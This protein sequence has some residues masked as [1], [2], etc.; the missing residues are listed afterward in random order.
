MIT[1]LLELTVALNAIS[2][3]LIS[4]FLRVSNASTFSSVKSLSSIF[5]TGSENVIVT[6]LPIPTPVASFPGEKVM[7]GGD[8]SLRV[9]GPVVWAVPIL[10]PATSYMEFPSMG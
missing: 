2:A 1:F 7:I 9:N 6:L 8:R 5:R 10:I 3:P 4:V